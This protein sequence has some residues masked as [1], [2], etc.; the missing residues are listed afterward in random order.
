M[1][2]SCFQSA[3]EHVCD[4]SMCF[5]AHQH[6]GFRRMSGTQLSVIDGLRPLSELKLDHLP[7]PSRRRATLSTL[8]ILFW[9]LAAFVFNV[10][11]LWVHFSPI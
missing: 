11:D 7:I 3:I 1:L 6:Q 9:D 4:D 5:G 2:Y 8:G 10:L